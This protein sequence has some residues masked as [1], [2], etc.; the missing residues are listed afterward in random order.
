MT[1]CGDARVRSVRFACC[2]SDDDVRRLSVLHV[3]STKLYDDKT[4]QPH[5]DGLLSPRMGPHACMTGMACVVCGL[6]SDRCAGHPGHIELSWG[7][8]PHP[9]FPDVMITTLLVP[10]PNLRAP[11][12]CNGRRHQHAWTQLLRAIMRARNAAAGSAALK[13][14]FFD[15]R[16]RTP[17]LAAKLRGKEGFMRSRLLGR[18]TG[19]S[20]RAVVVPNAGLPIDVVGVPKSFA[21]T[22]T[23]PERCA[24]FNLQRLRATPGTEPA[25]PRLGDVVERPLQDG[26]MVILNRQPTLSAHSMVGM[27]V[28]LMDDY[29]LEMNPLLCATFNADFDGDEMNVLVCRSVE[30]QAE[31]M[32]LLHPT[33]CDMPFI[34]DAATDQPRVGRLTLR[35]RY[36]E[37]L[38]RL[39][40]CD[41]SGLSVT[42]RDVEGLQVPPGA[43]MAAAAQHALEHT[44]AHNSLKRMVLGGKGKAHN[45]VSFARYSRGLSAREYFESART[46]REA[47]VLKQWNTPQAGYLF[48]KLS[49]FLD[50]LRCEYDGT[51]RN[52]GHVVR[53]DDLG[54]E[55]G[56][57]VGA[58][59]AANLSKSNTQTQ[60]DSFHHAGVSRAVK[61]V[62][63][64]QLLLGSSSCPAFCLGAMPQQLTPAPSD[65]RPAAP[66]T[67]REQTY[68]Y[69]STGKHAPSEPEATRTRFCGRDADALRQAYDFCWTDD[70]GGVVVTTRGPYAQRQ[71]GVPGSPASSLNEFADLVLP[72]MPTDA[73]CDNVH[74]VCATLGIEAARQAMHEFATELFPRTPTNELDAYLDFVC[75]TGVLRHA[76]RKHIQDASRPIASAGFETTLAVLKRAASAGTTDN[77]ADPTGQ[78][79]FNGTMQLPFD[80]VTCQPTPQPGHKRTN[81]RTQPREQAAQNAPPPAVYKPY[82]PGVVA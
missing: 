20:A 35:E 37:Q 50:A 26:D 43:S 44:D 68:H 2:A 4:G 76:T 58:H 24:P 79:V 65:G 27:K 40:Q 71:V 69:V 80:A 55:P 61:R 49:A 3:T 15:T 5:A 18:R 30:A 72:A 38:S 77:L 73:R 23:V 39:A 81:P 32:A 56:Q 14:Y 12:V 17:G 28:K 29:V 42:L 51:L 70:D 21:A 54:F 63:V 9:L 36:E 16:D 19:Y 7:P 62:S 74:Y 59:I 75:Y 33:R 78:I 13:R 53:F 1:K 47:L 48:R 57:F 34:Q 60:L 52:C 6:L 46:V 8:T 22:L 82:E 66:M 41:A 10:P 67:P 11:N 45:L 64:Q 31:A 25:E